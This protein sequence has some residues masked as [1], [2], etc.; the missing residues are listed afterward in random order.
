MSDAPHADSQGR[1]HDE[2]GQYVSLRDFIMAVLSEKEKSTEFS[3]LQLERALI[4]A[5]VTTQTAMAEA[6]TTV[7][8]RLVEAKTAA[9]AVTTVITKRL[10]NLESGGAPFASRLDESLS[11]LKSDVDI[12]KDNMVRTTVLDAL[13]EQTTADLKVQKR[14][15]RNLAWSIAA[16]FAVLAINLI[17]QYVT[18][19]P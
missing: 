18:R 12:L 7:E 3:R 15:I 16:T 10:D 17:Y 6:R 4:E 14:T 2:N 11:E 9:D 1:F 8:Q 19:H 5:R 13:R